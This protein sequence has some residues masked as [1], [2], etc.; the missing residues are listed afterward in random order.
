MPY[1]PERFD[2]QKQTPE[3]ARVDVAK[4]DAAVKFSIANENPA[5]KDLAIDLATSF[6]REPFDTP[7]GPLKSR[8]ALSGM[9]IKNGYVVAEWGDTTR[10]DMTFSVTK[11]FLSTV[12]GLV[13]Q[14]GLIRDVTDPVKDYMRRATGRTLREPAQR[15]DHLGSPAAA[16]ERL[17]GHALGQAR[18]GRSARRADARGLAEP[19]AAASPAR[20]TST[21]TCA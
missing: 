12:V 13:W 15:E 20:A 2:W 8:G 14:K 16:D 10:V 3:Q 4:L 11:S 19:Q 7:I 6:G 18:L 5:N 9:I 21:T 17:G 1:Y